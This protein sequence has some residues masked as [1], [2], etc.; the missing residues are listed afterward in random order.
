MRYNV[1]S[2]R[3]KK[4]TPMRRLFSLLMFLAAAVPAYA[5][6]DGPGALRPVQNATEAK[7]AAED[8]P[9]VLEGNIIRQIR[10][11]RYIFRDASGEIVVE[12]DDDIIGNRTVTPRH[13]V[14]LAGKVEKE[15]N[16]PVMD[17]DVL[18]ILKEG[19]Y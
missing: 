1:F 18:E 6:F 13:K 2:E 17:V 12:I 4:E 5:A 8:S 19:S 16:G 9:V 11:E 10:D 14:R 15:K 3:L 7:N